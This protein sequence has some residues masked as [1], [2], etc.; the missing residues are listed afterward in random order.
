MGVRFQNRESP[1]GAL[2]LRGL[3]STAGIHEGHASLK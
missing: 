3:P 2:D 1:D